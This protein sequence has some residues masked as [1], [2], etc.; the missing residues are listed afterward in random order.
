[1]EE[2]DPNQ[3]TQSQDLSNQQALIPHPPL[4]QKFKIKYLIIPGIPL[5]LIFSLSFGYLF[6]WVP[7]AQAEEY[8]EETSNDFQTVQAKV[9]KY[10]VAFTDITKSFETSR[11]AFYE[12][13]KSRS[14]FDALE[15]TKQDIEDINQTLQIISEAK[16]TKKN[17]EIPKDL[18]SLDNK[19][20]EYYSQVESGMKLLLEFEEF[21]MNMLKASGGDF[22]RELLRVDSVFKTG[23]ERIEV[24][25]YLTRLSQLADEALKRF[26]QL[27][28]H[29]LP[30]FHKEYYQTQKNQH[31]ILAQTIESVTAEI[32][33]GTIEGDETAVKLILESVEKNKLKNESRVKASEEFI[34]NSIIKSFF[35]KA[36]ELEQI[37]NEEFQ[38]LKE[39][40]GLEK[41]SEASP[42]PKNE[43]TDSASF[44]ATPSAEPTQ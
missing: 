35:D 19:L 6:W 24:L 3:H 18:M 10:E 12:I 38:V 41:K 33:R 31:T 37:I 2:N 40:Y 15:D 13:T 39:K 34:K 7:K 42:T 4:I 16:T 25:N 36:V 11:E 8:L 22:N 5:I 1:M 23:A 29:D 9:Q 43:S 32:K 44:Q 26:D 17:L 27:Q 30:Q 21:H 14:Y 28:I 20:D